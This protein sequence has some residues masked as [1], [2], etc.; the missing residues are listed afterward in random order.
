MCG[1]AGMFGRTDERQL[2][3]MTQMLRHR[4]P[5]GGAVWIGD[6]VG[7]GHRRLKIIDLS[8]EA[9]QPMLSEDGSCALTFNGEIF[10]YR[11][12]REE[13]RGHGY[14]FR[15]ESDSEVLLAACM[16]WGQRVTGHLVG[17]FAF[18][19]SDARSGLRM[20]VRDHLGVK[21]LYYAEHDGTLYFASEAKALLAVLPETR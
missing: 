20:L 9:A 11:E 1:I 4:G 2:R 21:P 13:L 8:D 12:L 14:R 17:Q 16:Q 15:S 6:G 18:A 10:N 3:I 5:D 7:F 19:Y